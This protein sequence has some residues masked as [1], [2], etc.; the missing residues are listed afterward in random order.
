MDGEAGALLHA[1]ESFVEQEQTGKETAEWVTCQSRK[2]EFDG[3]LLSQIESEEEQ[4]RQ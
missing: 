4:L 3:R 2:S 1:G